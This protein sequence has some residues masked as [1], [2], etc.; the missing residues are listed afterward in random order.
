[1]LLVRL[2]LWGL[3]SFLS[4][5]SASLSLS[6][7]VCVSMCVHAY[8]CLLYALTLV[9][10][11]SLQERQ[12]QTLKAR[13]KGLEGKLLILQQEPLKDETESGE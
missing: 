3:A 8:A 10:I 7:C 12:L 9:G 2:T 5:P 1:M 13:Q 4:F 6:L 11:S